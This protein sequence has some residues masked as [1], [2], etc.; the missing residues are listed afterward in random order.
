MSRDDD[1]SAEYERRYPQSKAGMPLWAVLL[2]V[3]GAIGLFGCGGV[4]VVMLGWAAV[5]PASPPPPIPVGSAVE[6]RTYTREEFR[7]MLTRKTQDEVK[8]TLGAPVKTSEDGPDSSWQYDEIT[9]DTVTGKIDAH[10]WVVFRGGRFASI[11]H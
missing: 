6:G 4:A 5:R 11:F 9:V 7:A 8:A 3:F 10:T 2:I 1:D